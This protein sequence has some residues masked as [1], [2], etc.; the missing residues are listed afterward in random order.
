MTS[1]LAGFLQ[2]EECE[3]K[4]GTEV[5]SVHVNKRKLSKHLKLLQTGYNLLEGKKKNNL[6][7]NVIDSS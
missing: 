2:L 6:S 7:I 5:I 1:Y 3:W 4:K